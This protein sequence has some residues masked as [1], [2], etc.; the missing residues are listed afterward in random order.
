VTWQVFVRGAAESDLEKL[1]EA[2]KSP[3]VSEMVRLGRAWSSVRDAPRCLGVEMFDDHL[4]GG[5]RIIY[6][7]D[8]ED[9]RIL[10][11]RI[12]KASPSG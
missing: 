12:R 8:H 3:L 11:V 4:A 2:E 10:V 1:S 9:E 6:V 5:F 7:V